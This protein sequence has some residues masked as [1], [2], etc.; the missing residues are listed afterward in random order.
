MKLRRWP[1]EYSTWTT[2]H[3]LDS[4]NQM[5][6]DVDG[7]GAADAVIFKNDYGRWY[8]ALSNGV[9]GFAHYAQWTDDHGSGSD[10]QIVA[11]VDGDGDS[12]ASDATVFF[13]D[14]ETWCVLLSNRSL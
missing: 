10:N 8:V 6:G 13:G 12:N 3:E 11:D 9:D 1:A 14:Q 4:D 2:G 7:D 5:L